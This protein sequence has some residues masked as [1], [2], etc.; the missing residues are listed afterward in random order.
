MSFSYT[1]R[2]TKKSESLTR[3]RAS[4]HPPP[5]RDQSY[6]PSN[7]YGPPPLLQ[8]KKS[9]LRWVFLTL[10]LAGRSWQSLPRQF[11]SFRC[12]GYWIFLVFLLAHHRNSRRLSWFT[13]I[14]IAMFLS[15]TLRGNLCFLIM[16][17][18]FCHMRPT[19]NYNYLTSLDYR[20]YL[21]FGHWRNWKPHTSSHCNMEISIH[22]IRF[23]YTVLHFHRDT[24][25]I[26]FYSSLFHYNSNN[27]GNTLFVD[28]LNIDE[29]LAQDE[30]LG[31]FRS[32]G[33]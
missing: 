13:I 20:R 32:H 11:S 31:W 9:W 10:I 18:R 29:Y 7:A 16:M 26:A 8:R 25:G 3:G 17:V 23:E 4:F 1:F 33:F 12:I 5:A 2:F 14:P 21:G 30:H 15:F 22:N 27:N 6:S 28:P 19:V 24:H